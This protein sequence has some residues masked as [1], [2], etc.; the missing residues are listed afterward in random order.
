VNIIEHDDKIEARI[1]ALTFD[2][3]DVVVSVTGQRALQG[4]NQEYYEQ[5]FRCEAHAGRCQ[6]VAW[7]FLRAIT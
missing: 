2:P 5:M 7:S 3:D 4:T 1:H 6:A